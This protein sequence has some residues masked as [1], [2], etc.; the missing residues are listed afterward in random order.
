MRGSGRRSAL[1][2]PAAR[3]VPRELQFDA[4]EQPE[5]RCAHAG[6]IDGGL[7]FGMRR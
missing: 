6:A 4:G 5:I 1:E 2:I 3:N 7:G